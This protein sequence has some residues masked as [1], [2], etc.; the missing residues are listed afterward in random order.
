MSVRIRATVGIPPSSGSA[1]SGLITLIAI[2]TRLR[3]D[4]N[5]QQLPATECRGRKD[6][7]TFRQSLFECQQQVHSDHRYLHELAQSGTYHT[8]YTKCT[9]IGRRSVICIC[10]RRNQLNSRKIFGTT[11]QI[12]RAYGLQRSHYY[13]TGL[14]YRRL[15]VT[16]RIFSTQNKHT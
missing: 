1:I 14:L 12:R 5:I 15:M 6:H 3:L 9:C 13:V 2:C 8:A 4:K 7:A 11:F 16:N 10:R